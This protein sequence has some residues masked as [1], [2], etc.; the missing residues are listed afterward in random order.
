MLIVSLR[1]KVFASLAPTDMRKGFP[2]LT[3]IVEKEASSEESVVSRSRT[4][5]FFCFSTGVA[6]D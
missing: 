2:G 1:T 6:I 5:I 3:G 4:A